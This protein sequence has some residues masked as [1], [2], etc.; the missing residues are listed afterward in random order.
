MDDNLDSSKNSWHNKRYKLKDLYESL[1]VIKNKYN[2]TQHNHKFTHFV[3]HQ[4]PSCIDHIYSNCANKIINVTTHK[5]TTSDH[6]IITA[7]YT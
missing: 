1:N 6:S 2:I 4:P 5:N 3:P 7:Q